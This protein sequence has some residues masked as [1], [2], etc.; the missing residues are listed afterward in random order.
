MPDIISLYKKNETFLPQHQGLE[1][2]SW[3]DGDTLLASGTVSQE[4]DEDEEKCKKR[5]Y[6]AAYGKLLNNIPDRN[7]S[8]KDEEG[9]HHYVVRIIGVSYEE[10]TV[11]MEMCCTL[12]A[13]F[14]TAAVVSATA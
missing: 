1:R 11:K 4:I 2:L 9:L 5:A 10:D 14:Y 8:F 3:G 12:V 13:S 6:G 7:P